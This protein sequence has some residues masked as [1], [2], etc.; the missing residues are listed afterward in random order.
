MADYP[1]ARNERRVHERPTERLVFPQ[2]TAAPPSRTF[3]PPRSRSAV[4]TK[5]QHPGPTIA[6]SPAARTPMRQSRCSTRNTL[7]VKGSLSLRPDRYDEFRGG[8][9]ADN[10]A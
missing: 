9:P 6:E 7:E 3:L 4:R 2:G 1:N 8:S 5:H 10:D